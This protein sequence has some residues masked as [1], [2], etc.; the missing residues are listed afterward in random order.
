M[1]A[2]KRKRL[3]EARDDARAEVRIRLGSSAN[4][5]DGSTPRMIDGR[6]P[7]EARQVGW[8]TRERRGTTIRSGRKGGLKFVPHRDAEPKPRVAAKSYGDDV[9][10]SLTREP[11]GF[12]PQVGLVNRAASLP[13][14]D[15]E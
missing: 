2:N 3:A 13:R 7:F 15:G 12:G 11:D 5:Y 6:S 14:P 1:K 4:A 8:N 10:D 9:G